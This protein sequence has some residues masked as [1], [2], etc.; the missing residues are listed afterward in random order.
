MLI[1]PSS[2]IINYSW[3]DLMAVED[4]NEDQYKRF[5]YISNQA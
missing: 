3:N 4:L 2:P 5:I 1:M